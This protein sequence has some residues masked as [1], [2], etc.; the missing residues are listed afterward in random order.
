ML[1]SSGTS[2][3]CFW[4][5][6]SLAFG[7]TSLSTCLSHRPSDTRATSDTAHDVSSPLESCKQRSTTLELNFCR[8]STSAT[9]GRGSGGSAARTRKR[10]RSL[11]RRRVTG[12]REAKG[13]DQKKRGDVWISLGVL[14]SRFFGAWCH[15][16]TPGRFRWR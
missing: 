11:Q 3:I 9:S 16:R 12:P 15:P 5:L 6:E 10:G 13:I 7:A 8:L 2:R 14:M 1:T 4:D